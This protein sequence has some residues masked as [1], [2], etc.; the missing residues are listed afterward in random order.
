MNLIF[1]LQVSNQ[2]NSTVKKVPLWDIIDASNAGIGWVINL[3][4]VIMLGYTIFVFVERF[5]ALRK[6]TKEESGLL[7]GVK[8][9]LSNGNID[10]AKQLCLASESPIAKML[11]KGIS[12]IGT[13]KNE[14]IA[15]TIE[16]T[17]KFEIL[18]LEQRLNFL[19]TASGAAPMIGF[20]GTVIGMVVVF[21]DLQN[22]QSLELKIIAPGIMTAMITT[23][24]GLIV[25]IIAFMGYNYLVGQIGKVVYQMENA[26]LEFMDLLNQS[27]K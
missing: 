27:G 8:S 1:L 11:L 2:P 17:G 26:A 3:I 15:A 23:V 24:G 12:R 5:L 13:A 19:A 9:N 20:L 22:A 14:S 6:A 10:G 21:I 18:R 25:G 16:N 4:L 7:N